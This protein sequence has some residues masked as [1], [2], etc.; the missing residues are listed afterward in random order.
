MPKAN[1]EF[2]VREALI[3]VNALAIEVAELKAE[4]RQ[5]RHEEEDD[6]RYKVSQTGRL[7]EL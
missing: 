5:L 6:I 1:L 2:L 4:I 7:V 3:K